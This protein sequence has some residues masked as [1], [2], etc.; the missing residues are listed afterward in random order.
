M[1]IM[2][3]I[4]FF[5]QAV[6]IYAARFTVVVTA[7]RIAVLS[8]EHLSARTEHKGISVLYYFLVGT[9]FDSGGGLVP[10]CSDY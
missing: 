6:F 3:V 10:V 4:Y 5:F 8:E 7:E 9:L 2:Q 1:D